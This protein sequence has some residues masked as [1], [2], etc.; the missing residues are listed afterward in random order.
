MQASRHNCLNLIRLLTAFQVMFG[1]ILLHLDV[2]V[3]EGVS[4]IV[5]MFRGVP[6]FFGL[7]GFLI[8]FSIGRTENWK[9]YAKKRFWRIYPELWIGVAV[10]AIVLLLMYRITDVVK[11]VLFLFGQATIFQFWTPDS[12]R[13]Y[14]CGTPNGSLWTICVTIQFYVI[15]WGLYKFLHGKSLRRWIGTWLGVLCLSKFLELLLGRFASII[16]N[17]LYGQTIIRYLWLF[18]LGSFLA[19]F[20]GTILPYLKKYWLLLLG[21]SGLIYLI[22][23]DISVGYGVIQSI[24]MFAG[25]LG[26]AYRFP[27]LEIK[28]DISYGIYIFHMTVVNVLI[29]QGM[30]GSLMS[31]VVV[32]GVSCVLAFVSSEMV[33]NKRM[34]KRNFGTEVYSR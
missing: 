17:K 25:V 6:I 19:E 8:W 1:H 28:R 12:L 14:G 32:V 3:P 24:F 33:G 20:Y 10:E 11:F 4:I 29:E 23:I 15:A 27:K 31:V 13:G 30:T 22:G 34:K 5:W 16:I 21:F 26:I 18:V 9:V 2:N 7:S